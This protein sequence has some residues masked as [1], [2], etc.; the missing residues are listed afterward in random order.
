MSKTVDGNYECPDDPGE[1]GYLGWCRRRS[2]TDE[3]ADILKELCTGQKVLEIGTGLGVSTRAIATTARE[4]V[5]IDIDPW[6]HEFEFPANVRLMNEI[7]DEPFDLTFI[8][9]NHHYQNV[10]EDIRKAIGKIILHDYYLDDVRM[11][12]QDSR[13]EII[14][15]YDTRCKLTVCASR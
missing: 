7:P 2:V 5:S 3:E 14:K 13:L 9:G 6:C 12:V 15:V 1:A 4:V 11:A 8:D 10:M